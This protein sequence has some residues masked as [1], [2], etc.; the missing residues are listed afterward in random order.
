MQLLA[1]NETTE[2]FLFRVKSNAVRRVR[3]AS[4]RENAV[5]GRAYSSQNEKLWAVADQLVDAI[6]AGGQHYKRVRLC[7]E[8]E[9]LVS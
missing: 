5:I 8:I 4:V 9:S 6:D 7:Q 1:R 2:Q 3:R